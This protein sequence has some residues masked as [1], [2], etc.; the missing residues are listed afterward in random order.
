MPAWEISSPWGR[1]VRCHSGF[2]PPADM[3]PPPPPSQIWIP[4]PI[5]PYEHRLNYNS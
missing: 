4:L 3:D 1:R 5:F 2:G